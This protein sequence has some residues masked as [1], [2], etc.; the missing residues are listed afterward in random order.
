MVGHGGGANQAM[1]KKLLREC[2]PIIA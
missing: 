2:P 1:L